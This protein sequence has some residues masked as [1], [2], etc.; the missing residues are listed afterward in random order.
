MNTSVSILGKR[1][2]IVAVTSGAVLSVVPG[3]AWGAITGTAGAVVKVPAPASVVENG[4]ESNTVMAAFDEM[5]NVTLSS[6]ACVD[7]M[8]P[9][10]YSSSSAPGG[11]IAAGTLVSSHLLSADPVGDPI[12]TKAVRYRGSITFDNPILGVAILTAS[13]DCTDV[14]GGPGTTY[15]TGLGTR[16]LEQGDVVVQDD[17]KTLSVNVILHRLDQ[18]RV[19]TAGTPQETIGCQ[20]CTPGYWKQTQHFDSW[21]G[22]KPSDSFEAVVGRDVFK[23][24]PT[25][26]KVLGTGGGGVNALGRHAAAGLLNAKSA[27]VDYAYT[28][29]EVVSMFQAAVDSKKAAV[30][31]ATKNRLEKANE[32]GCP[33]N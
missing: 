21:M 12:P 30:I 9:G 23:G 2:A 11:S 32:A 17:H 22:Y 7:F 19:I 10:T 33:L 26:L 5:Q 3:A 31:E 20:G 16:A 8:G 15:P 18:L 4:H 24:S 27:G 14:L 29:S 13:L 1:I 25:T 6:P 28:S